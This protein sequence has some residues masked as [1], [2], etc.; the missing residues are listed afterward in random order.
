MIE[1][2]SIG[3][4]VYNAEKFLKEA[5]NSILN[6]SHSN[7]ELIIVDDGSTDKSINI[8]KSFNDKRIVLYQDGV[9]K[10]LPA[11]LNEISILAKGRYLARMDADDIMHPERIKRQLEIL[12][13]NIDIDVLGTNAYSIDENNVI[14]GVRMT[15]YKKPKLTKVKGF[16]HPTIIA[17][18][19]WYLRNPYNENATRIED[20]ELW[21]RTHN[22]YNF[23]VISEPLL[24]YREFGEKY[25]MKYF[26]SLQGHK[27]VLTRSFKISMYKF[28]IFFFKNYLF[29]L[30]KGIV[31]F[32]FNIFKIEHILISRR[33]FELN[34]KQITEADYYLKKSINE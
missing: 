6:Q 28:I 29:T 9:N 31:Y 7:F 19:S 33:N 14:N 18:T 10:G 20:Y 27:Y 26:K 13:K 17:E 8:I 1:F 30:L 32:T 24:Y 2:V 5:I 23:A 34:N 11:R 16:I 4:P 15:L 25:F 21:Q 12:E 3:L 22:N